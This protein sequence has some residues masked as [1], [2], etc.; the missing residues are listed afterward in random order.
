MSLRHRAT[1]LAVVFALAV[2]ACEPS[3]APMATAPVTSYE[4]WVLDQADTAPGGGGALY[5]FRG[6]DLTGERAPAPAITV[7]LA[8]AALGVGDGI[9]RR[10]HML[11]FNR[12]GTHGVI[13]YVASGHVQVVR[14]SDRK[15]VASIRMTAGA[16]GAIQAHAAMVTP[17]DAAIVVVNQNGKKLQRIRADF[18]A[19]RYALDAAA[20][21]DLG[22]LQ[23]ATHPDNAPIW[24]VPTPDGRFI[25]VT[26]RGG[27]AYVVDFAASPMRV[28]ASVGNDV[29][30][31]NG[32]AGVGRGN[33]LWLTAGGG[34]AAAPNVYRVYHVDVAGLPGTFK[35]EPQ[36]DRSGAVDAHGLVLMPSGRYFWLADR[37]A[38]TIDIF[39]VSPRRLAGSMSLATGPLQGKRPAP[40]LL[41]V[42][43]DGSLVFAT[44]RGKEPLTGNVPAAGNAVGDSPGVLILR[45]VDAGKSGELRLHIPLALAA[46]AS[47]VD[48]HGIRVRP[49]R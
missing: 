28:V 43:P 10:P 8:E 48:P 1:S 19:D 30:A 29:L 41:D 6:A 4:L 32:F 9:G 16:G 40:D 47:I 46:G 25:V 45:S 49:I 26:L 33:D 36:F 34:T 14:A 35:P 27:G 22:A 18:R 31:P 39:E 12:T 7:N 44:L 42:S 13:A 17:D 20:D 21:L 37:A 3:G 24:P 2:A 11:D 15:V 23:D 38:N 5:V